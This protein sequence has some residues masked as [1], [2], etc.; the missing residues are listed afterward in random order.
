MP[1]IKVTS[2]ELKRAIKLQPAWYRALIRECKVELTKD[3]SGTNYNFYLLIDDKSKSGKEFRHTINEN[4]KSGLGPI[5][6]AACSEEGKPY[7]VNPEEEHEFDTD[8][9]AGKHVKI[10]IENEIYQG[11]P[12][13]KIK[14]W[15]PDFY[16]T[17]SIPF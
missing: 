14:G 3:R 12:V 15:L 11:N 7:K 13:N 16:D 1:V 5:F 10:K 4:A 9:V 2:E 6:E 8:D 17:D